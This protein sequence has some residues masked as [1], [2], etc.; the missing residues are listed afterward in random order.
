MSSAQRPCMILASKWG[1]PVL[2]GDAAR[3][4]SGHLMPSMQRL[5]CMSAVLMSFDTAC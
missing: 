4:R 3:R 1:Q 2:L 5:F